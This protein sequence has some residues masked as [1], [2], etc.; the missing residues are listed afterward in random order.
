MATI[1]LGGLASGIDTEAI[2]KI[3]LDAERI[4]ITHLQLQKSV[5]SVQNDAVTAIKNSLSSLKTS[6]NKLKDPAFFSS[7]LATSS[8]TA[9]LTASA[10]TTAAKTSH[11]IL[12]SKIAT[13]A[14]L[15]SGTSLGPSA[16][17][18]ANSI[19]PA[20][21]VGSNTSYGNSLTLGTFTVNGT[22]ITI[23][24]ASTLNS[25]MADIDAVANTDAVTY[26]AATDTITIDPTGA[27]TITL[28]S[29]GDTSNFLTRSRLYTT[30]TA[31]G[32]V[33]SL[34]SIGNIDTTQIVNTAASRIATSATLTDGTFTVNGV[35]ITIDKDVDTFQNIL[36]RI[37]ASTAGVYASYDSVED[38]IVLTNKSTGSTQITVVEG[39]SNF[40]SSMKLTSSTSQIVQG[41]DTEF[42]VGGAALIHKSTDNILTEVESGITGLTLTVLKTNAS[43]VTVT[44]GADT[45][46]I[47]TEVTSFITQFNSTVSLIDSYTKPKTKTTQPTDSASILANDSIAV[48]L[49]NSLRSLVTAAPGTAT[50][51]Q[52]EDV[53]VT[54]SGDNNLLTFSD[55]SKLVSALA[56]YLDQ[57]KFLFSDSTNG[58]MTKLS[59]FI[60]T[61]IDLSIG[62]YPTRITDISSRQTRLDG[63]IAAL[64]RKIAQEEEQLV[65]AFSAMEQFQATAANILS[66]L[67]TASTTS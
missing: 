57:V 26:D 22:I 4:P 13:A 39:T 1:R 55:T 9:T 38:R 27:T 56:Q 7:N 41:A 6:L 3:I 54:A 14:Q 62:A 60:D 50:I 33:T 40:A 43:A 12:V 46:K 18:I 49:G 52:I 67:S 45:A 63:D 10:G 65:A 32:N 25:I 34:T 30:G 29:A 5:L 15:K 59:N 36:D 19:A 23:T 42:T 35:S 2:I 53:G 61:Q 24:A 8:D 58:V 66:F 17:K 31:G 47:Q 51:R 44:V 48:T 11:T 20:D 28:G 21:T 16:Q 37:T 64:E